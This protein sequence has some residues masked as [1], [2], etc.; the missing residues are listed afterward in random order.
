MDL[1]QFEPTSPEEFIGEPQ[2]QWC[3]ILLDSVRTI[4]E[5]GNGNLKVLIKGPPGIGKTSMARVVAHALV[6]KEHR[7]VDLIEESAAD[8]QIDWVRQLKS[9]MHY[10]PMGGFKAII[11]DEAD[12]LPDKCETLFLKIMDDLPRGTVMI[13]TSNEKQL[14]KRFEDRC[15]RVPLTNP[16]ES[17][18]AKWLK[19]NTELNDRRIQQLTTSCKGVR[20]TLAQATTII[21]ARR[22]SCP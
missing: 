14:S 22:T 3:R 21:L 10:V 19:D 1:Q 2:Q 6:D 12:E 11:V 16:N 20:S 18:M 17:E 7:I 9:E 15:F 5:T 13:F 4:K 8:M